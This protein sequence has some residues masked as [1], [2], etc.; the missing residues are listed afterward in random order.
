MLRRSTKLTSLHIRDAYT[1]NSVHTVISTAAN[2]TYTAA[3]INTTWIDRNTN[4]LSRSDTMPTSAQLYT[5]FGSPE[6]NATFRFWIKNTA[7]AA[8]TITILAGTGMTL[9]G[10]M[11]VA[12]NN[13]KEFLLTFNSPTTTTLYS[14]GTSVF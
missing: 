1:F 5:Q 6:A 12:Q 13:L 2:V 3:Q 7:G 8:E 11:T 14:L 10:T 4:G 9:V